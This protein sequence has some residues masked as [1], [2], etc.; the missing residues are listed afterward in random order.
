[1]GRDEMLARTL[2]EAAVTSLLFTALATAQPTFEVASI[3]PNT[4]GDRS[5]FSRNAEG[6]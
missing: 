2:N 5:S 6:N 3:K 4:S 1:M